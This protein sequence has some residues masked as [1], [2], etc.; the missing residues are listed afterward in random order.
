MMQNGFNF[1]S[2]EIAFSATVDSYFDAFSYLEY[3]FLYPGELRRFIQSGGTIAWGIVP[4]FGFTG[5]ET[6]EDLSARL[7]GGLEKLDALGLDPSRVAEQALLT[8]ACGMGT[9]EPSAADRV[10]ELLRG[11]SIRWVQ[12]G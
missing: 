5:N 4:T 8:P 9:M 12:K 11:L 6:I 10:L 3:F 7:Q 1:R 2:A